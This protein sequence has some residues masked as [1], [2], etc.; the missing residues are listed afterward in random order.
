VYDDISSSFTANENFIE[1][2][3]KVKPKIKIPFSTALGFQLFTA[4]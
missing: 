4:S 2:E 1:I 3:V